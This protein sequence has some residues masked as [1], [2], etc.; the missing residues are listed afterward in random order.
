MESGGLMLVFLA[1]FMVFLLVLAVLGFVAWIVQRQCPPRG[2]VKDVK[3]ELRSLVEIYEKAQRRL[4]GTRT[5]RCTSAIRSSLGDEYDDDEE[6]LGE[7]GGRDKSV[8]AEFRDEVIR[9]VRGMNPGVRSSSGK[10]ELDPEVEVGPYGTM[11]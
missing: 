11:Q 8:D 5:R 7:E 6:D 9:T 2:D 4:E 1:M 3:E 10:F